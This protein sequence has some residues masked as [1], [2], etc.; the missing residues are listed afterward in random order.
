MRIVRIG[1]GAGFSGDRITPAVELLKKGELDY[2]VFECLAERTLAL[3]QLEKLKDPHRGY[4]H[5]LEERMRQILPLCMDKNT[6]IITSMGSANPQAAG[7]KTIEIA[8][9]LG[10]KGLKV[11]TV[12]GD[13][14]LEHLKKEGYS[15]PE[16]T[17]SANAYMGSE[18]MVDAL[19]KGADVVITGRVGDPSLYL[20]PLRHEFGWRD[21]DWN[22]IAKGICIGHLMECGAQITGGYYAEPGK[23]EVPDLANIGFPVAE[24]SE[25]GGAVI[26]KL[27]DAGG[28]V[29]LD[30]CKEQ[31]LYE[32]HNPARY[33][34]AEVFADLSGVELRE[35]G[36]DRVL[37]TGAEGFG[38]PRKLKVVIGYKNGYTGEGQISYGG[39][40]ALSRAELA[41]KIVRRRLDGA[42]IGL[43]ELRI[44]FIGYSSLYGRKIGSPSEVRLR[45]VGKADRIE[46][47]ERIGFEVESLYL[48]GPAGGGGVAKDVHQLIDLKFEYIDRSAIKP[49][50][51][52]EES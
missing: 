5:Y 29:S 41:G 51:L 13:D 35:V 8:R 34:T 15:F 49:R 52:M 48:N 27:P 19:R 32:I 6:K 1:T 28:L 14:V 31:L 26:T 46:D 30:V 25:D 47:A 23:K 18:M 24:V 12:L 22:M 4:D 33:A 17:V 37:V 38:R 9:E 11:G 21:D 3:A 44:D 2:I 20:A 7:K 40:G 10:L 16:G 50:V 43:R 36:K 39:T 45:V 42:C